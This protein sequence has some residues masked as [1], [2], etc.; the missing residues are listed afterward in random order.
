MIN[1]AEKL[2]YD[3]LTS[4]VDDRYSAGFIS[5]GIYYTQYDSLLSYIKAKSL[6]VIGQKITIQ[7]EKITVLTDNIV[8]LTASGVTMIDVYNGNSFSLKFD[9]SF[10]YQKLDNK[11]KVIQSHQSSNR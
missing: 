9:W 10:V 1:A 8:L 3:K 7:K 2:D 11:W 4:G 6:G 5:G